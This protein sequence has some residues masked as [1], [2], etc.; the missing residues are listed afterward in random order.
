MN[1]VKLAG[2]ASCQHPLGAVP[3]WNNYAIV[4]QQAI[5]CDKLS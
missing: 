4:C 5:I 3:K 2:I 1:Y